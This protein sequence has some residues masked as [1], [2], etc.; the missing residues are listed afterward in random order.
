[1]MF[2][3]DDAVNKKFHVIRVYCEVLFFANNV[4]IATLQ[5]IANCNARKARVV[6]SAGSVLNIQTKCWNLRADL[7]SVA[8]YS[9][10]FH[11]R[12]VYPGRG[13]SCSARQC[14]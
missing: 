9:P 2:N 8:R 14:A 10:G 1:M 5:L 7:A 3:T 11:P 4:N 13:D 6:G 12:Y